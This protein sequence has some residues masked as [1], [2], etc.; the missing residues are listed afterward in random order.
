[1]E[2]ELFGHKKGAFSGALYEKKGLFEVANG[3]TIFLDEVG[4]LSLSIQAKL[5][6]V[7]QEK[8]FKRVGGTEDILVDVRII[9]A[10]NKNLEE[11]A[12]RGL[13]R[14]DLYYRLNVIQIALPSLR[15]R[16]E[17]IPLLAEHF[18][19]K[20]SQELGKDV[21]EISDFA[22]SVLMEYNFPGNVRELE[23]IIERSVALETSNIVLPESLSLSLF[24]K[25][26][27][28]SPPKAEKWD[29]PEAGLNLEETIENFEKSLILRAF[30]KS[31]RVKKKA[32]ELLK[33]SF[34]S[35]RYKLKKYGIES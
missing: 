33:I 4:D 3:G 19:K 8:T 27:D 29:I 23:N 13:F 7:I 26:E 10:T 32:A 14:E 16:R 35:M 31:G 17:D 1:L 11:E 12:I 18:L 28:K 30:E 24:K 5:L 25:G 34:R 22:M 2:S 20:Y 6:R 15:E 9:S 21:R